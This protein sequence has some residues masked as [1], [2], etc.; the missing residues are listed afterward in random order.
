MSPLIRRIERRNWILWTILLTASLVW[1]NWKFLLGVAAGGGL[2]LVGFRIL[3]GVVSRVL[4]LPSHRARGR[5]VAYHY[6]WMGALFGILALLLSLKLVDPVGL[7]LGLS[8][9]VLNLILSGV[10]DFR[11]IQTEV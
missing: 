5:I 11:R 3:K 6:G 10:V 1:G 9:V 7:L 8:V 2:S 4:P